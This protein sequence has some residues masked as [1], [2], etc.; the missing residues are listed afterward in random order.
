[1]N[2]VNPVGS[3]DG[4][5]FYGPTGLNV[6]R[7]FGIHSNDFLH[8][9]KQL[10]D[11]GLKVRI[12]NANILVDFVLYAHVLIDSGAEVETLIRE[13]NT[14]QKGDGA[15]LAH[16]LSLSKLY[17]HYWISGYDVRI[18]KTHKSIS[19]ADI[20]I[21]GVECDLK[22]R[23]DQTNRRMEKHNDLLLS[24]KQEEYN[25]ILSS[26]TRS[27]H[28]DLMSAFSS[29]VKEGFNQ[30][31]CVF[32]DLSSHLHSW[33]YY[34][35][36]TMERAGAIHGLSYTPVPAIVNTC[37]LFSPDNAHNLNIAGFNPKAYWGYLQVVDED[38]PHGKR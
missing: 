21:N 24:G 18:Q 13:F 20:V 12:T 31:A 26:E 5:V 27:L 36:K 4:M 32:L 11:R 8:L 25:E 19:K 34:R 23:H 33:N 14:A 2:I 3:D 30:A 6:E 22:V 10:V 37:I 38:I 1:M 28:E 7:I 35:L 17:Y 9:H 16:A 29:R 15:D